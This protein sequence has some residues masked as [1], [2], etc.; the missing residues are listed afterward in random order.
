KL[1]DREEITIRQNHVT[2]RVGELE[3]TKEL[4][5]DGKKTHTQRIHENLPSYLKDLDQLGIENPIISNLVI[6]NNWVEKFAYLC[7]ILKDEKFNKRTNS[8]SLELRGKLISR[9]AKR[10][11]LLFNAHGQ[12]II[13]AVQDLNISILLHMSK[14]DFNEVLLVEAKWLRDEEI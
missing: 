1:K 3:F 12:N 9:I 4:S 2:I 13:Q 14:R 5:R 6:R 11:F 7:N 8:D 10:V